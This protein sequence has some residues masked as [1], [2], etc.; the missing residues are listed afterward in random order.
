LDGAG[1]DAIDK[2]FSL[3]KFENRFWCG[4]AIHAK[5]ILVGLFKPYLQTNAGNEVLRRV[6]NVTVCATV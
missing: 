4:I 5:E 1:P 3:Q 2:Q 6:T